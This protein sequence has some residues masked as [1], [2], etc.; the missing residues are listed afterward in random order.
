MLL[1]GE[2]AEA[3]CLAVEVIDNDE[4]ALVQFP[5]SVKAVLRNCMLGCV[6]KA[7]TN[8]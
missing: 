4:Q 1:C 2:T 6:M 5:L 7:F 3:Q 8:T